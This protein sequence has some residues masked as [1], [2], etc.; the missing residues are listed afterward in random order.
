MSDT[1]QEDRTEAPTPRRRQEAAEKGQGARSQEVTTAFLLLASAGALTMGVPAIF[2]TMAD[3]FV[4]SIS[5]LSA[6]S[7]GATGTA[8]Y[9]VAM[10][11]RALSALAPIPLALG[12]TALAIGAL[13]GRGIITASPL[14]P[15][16]SRLDPIKKAKQIWGWKAVSE[17]VKSLLKFGVVFI[18]VGFT[19]R[20]AIIEVEVLGQTSPAALLDFAGRYVIRM[21]LSVG[22][23]YMALAAADYGFQVW[24]HEKQ[25]R[26]TREEVKREFKDSEGDQVVKVKRRT[27]AR[28]QA[29]HRM[30]K[31][32][33]DADVVIT[34]PTRIAV[35]LK[36]D[37]DVAIAP[38]VLA[39]GE[40]LVAERIREL[41]KEA[42]VPLVENKVLARALL[43][44]AKVGETIPMDLFVAVAEVLAF[45][46]RTARGGTAGY[47][48]GR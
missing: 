21:F 27:I 14:K 24:Q 18:A 31:S 3:I 46:Y 6:P 37:P 45:V 19:L 8:E 39:L 38:M 23:A 7:V 48:G 20:A 16:L 22:A 9:V 34:N 15:D 1:P 13:Q 26:M 4:M 17:L 43:A 44:T 30:L 29:R 35:A 41:A 10:G 33:A 5:G 32:V 2:A 42:G 11:G 25:I 12:G 47:G 40:R 28:E 36:Y